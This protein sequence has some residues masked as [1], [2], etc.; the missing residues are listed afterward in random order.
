VSKAETICQKVRS[1][2]D[3][4]QAALLRV[5]D[6]LVPA[7]TVAPGAAID[8]TAVGEFEEL[9]ETW[10]PDT[11]FCSFTEQRAMH[12]AYQRIIG[13]GWVAVP[14]ILRELQRK[15][16]H[17]LWALQAITGEEPAD[18]AETLSAAAERWLHWGRERGLLTDAQ[19]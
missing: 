7:G 11:R 5:V 14:M 17:W 2:P 3:S 12:P 19:G 10:R 18:R 8:P 16:D 1:L 6:L 4:A 9:A 13:M 15:P